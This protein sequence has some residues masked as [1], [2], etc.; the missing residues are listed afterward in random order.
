M[1]KGMDRGQEDPPPGSSLSE[2]ALVR[3]FWIDV[4]GT[5]VGT[6]VPS[7]S[8]P[9]VMVAAVNGHH[10][11]GRSRVSTAEF[12]SFLAGFPDWTFPW[13]WTVDLRGYEFQ[14]SV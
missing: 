12:A 7:S 11:H 4:F 9:P 3:R 1:S 6:S 14:L 8:E 5:N 10:P 2:G 13:A